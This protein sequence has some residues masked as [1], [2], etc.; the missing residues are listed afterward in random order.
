MIRRAHP[1]RLPCLR[2]DRRGVT[3]VEF[4][5]IAPVLLL[6]LMGIYDMGYAI[7]VDSV[8]QGALQQAA[9]NSTLE[10]AAGSTATIDQGV[11]NMVKRVSPGAT[12]A[13]SR[14][15][16]SSFTNV[17]RPEDFTDVN[18][19]GVCDNGEPY[20]DANGNGAWDADR[21]NSGQGG[22]RDAVLYAVTV[23]YPRPFAMASLARFSNTVTLKAQTVLR[24]QPYNIQITLTSA[25]NCP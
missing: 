2:A 1:A 5:L 20:E 21:A 14:K 18:T 11:T 3:T 6:M 8:L 9:R 10:G 23:T 25:R 13:F 12:L 15:S 22:A 19:N 4:A 7:Y 17:G 24:N 16:Y